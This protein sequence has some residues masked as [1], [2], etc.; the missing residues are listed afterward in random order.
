MIHFSVCRFLLKGRL[1]VMDGL[2]NTQIFQQR[3]AKYP[4]YYQ[5][6]VTKSHKPTT[7][8]MLLK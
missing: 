1:S 2:D 4:S 5:C 3:K 8:Q 6:P 7:H